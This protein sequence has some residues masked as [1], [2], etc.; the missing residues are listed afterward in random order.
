MA[1]KD[2]VGRGE[3]HHPRSLGAVSERLEHGDGPSAELDEFPGRG[4]ELDGGHRRRADDGAV[5]GWLEKSFIIPRPP[6]AARGWTMYIGAVAG[7][8]ANG[9]AFLEPS[10]AVIL[11]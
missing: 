2:D 11:P 9:M 5:G 4:G 8:T 6:N 10:S 1:G 3:R 7:L